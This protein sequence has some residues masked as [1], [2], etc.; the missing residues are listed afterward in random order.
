MDNVLK[1]V[2]N[3]RTL[4]EANDFLSS[5]DSI[6]EG[7]FKLNNNID[8][9]LSE[10]MEMKSSQTIRK[11]LDD[12]NVLISDQSSIEKVLSKAKE[13]LKNFQTVKI[14]IAIEPT[15]NTITLIHDW[16]IN[17]LKI[18]ILLDI[19]TDKSILGGIIISLDGVYKDLSVKKK[20]EEIFRNKRSELIKPILT[21]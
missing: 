1:D 18:N 3:I 16:F 11:I 15:E 14:T 6:L 10:S 21:K 20:L 2:P 17:N 13:E 4:K 9:I 19:N 12:N 7:L 5:I 8:K